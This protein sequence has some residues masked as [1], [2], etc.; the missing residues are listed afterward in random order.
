MLMARVM[1]H[2]ALLGRLWQQGV[3]IDDH[4]ALSAA[5]AL[6]SGALHPTAV[7]DIEL[8][9]GWLAAS[10]GSPNSS[11]DPAHLA[12]AASR[13]LARA[14]DLRAASNRRDI[15]AIGGVMAAIDREMAH[16]DGA[17][18]R[19]A[20]A[21]AAIDLAL[22]ETAVLSKDLGAAGRCLKRVAGSGPPAFRVA[23]LE[24]QVTLLLAR[25]HLPTALTRARQAIALAAQLE[26]PVQA[27]RSQILLGLVAYLLR[28]ADTMRAALLP[29]ASLPDG[30]M[31]RVLL[32][33]LDPPEQALLSLTQSLQ[34]AAERRDPMGYAICALIG[35]RAYVRIGRRTDALI[36]T[37][38]ACKQLRDVAP[39]LVIAIEDETEAWRHEWGGEPFAAAQ[40]EAM[41]VLAR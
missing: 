37:S 16:L 30:F 41:A 18:P 17:D 6:A 29:L 21:R 2:H 31:A 4:G 19:G 20:V 34:L 26:R 36:T 23:A 40:R 1:D 27:M 39:E 35:G 22:A 10:L 3:G 12:G 5:R 25:E 24:R 38:A 7:A 14:I 8:F 9:A 15:A 13:L 28:D 32:S 33:G 11:L